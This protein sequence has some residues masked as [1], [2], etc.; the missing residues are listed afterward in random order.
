MPG[1]GSVG[2][3]SL[4]QQNAGYFVNQQFQF[5]YNPDLVLGQVAH[6]FGDRMGFQELELA[7]EHGLAAFNAGYEPRQYSRLASGAR[8]G[9]LTAP[10][11]PNLPQDWRYVLTIEAIDPAGGPSQFR[12]VVIDADERL[13][14]SDLEEA[15]V[16]LWNQTLAST[17]YDSVSFAAAGY[18]RVNKVGSVERRS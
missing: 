13:R 6:K 2:L 7:Y 17:G 8:V 11:N 9:R 15:V 14:R 5:G 1:L 16:A 3:S 10:V 18:V 4:I 12:Q